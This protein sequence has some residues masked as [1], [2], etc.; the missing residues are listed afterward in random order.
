LVSTPLRQ[1]QIVVRKIGHA[2]MQPHDLKIHTYS[3]VL[4]LKATHERAHNFRPTVQQLIYPIPWH[5]IQ[6]ATK[7][8]A[9]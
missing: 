4:S 5:G 7:L 3:R 2:E 8:N 6:E 1:L 9:P